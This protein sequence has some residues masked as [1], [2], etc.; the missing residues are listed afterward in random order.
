LTVA[1][2]DDLRVGE[3]ATYRIQCEDVLL[4]RGPPLRISARNVIEATVVDIERIGRDALVVLDSEGLEWRSRI[5]P[6]AV[7]ELE[8]SR[9]A[10][11]RLVIKTHSFERLR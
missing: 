1:A 10:W 7:R 4:L 6:A 9:G 2:A 11:V 8:L 3:H 5:T